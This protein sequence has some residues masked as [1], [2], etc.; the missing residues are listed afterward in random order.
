[1]IIVERPIHLFN[2]NDYK[3]VCSMESA[4]SN[5]LQRG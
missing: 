5:I 4:D 2:V 3:I 1:L